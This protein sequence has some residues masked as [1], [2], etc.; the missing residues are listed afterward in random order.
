MNFLMYFLTLSQGQILP[1]LINL[2]HDAL[3][4]V[5]KTRFA[6]PPPQKKASVKPL[7]LIFCFPLFSLIE[8]VLQKIQQQQATAIIVTPNW[9]I[10]FWYPMLVQLMEDTPV[11]I[12]KQ[13]TT[14]ALPYSPNC[15]HP[16]CPILQLIGCLVSGRHS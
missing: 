11:K 8:R 14:L 7:K 3:K 10:E 1:R 4:F 16:L 9:K 12:I 2:K 15:R 13:Q 5:G 6:P